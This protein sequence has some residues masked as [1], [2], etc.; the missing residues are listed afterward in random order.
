[1]ENV[2]ASSGLKVTWTRTEV[3][4]ANCEKSNYVTVYIGQRPMMKKYAREPFKIKVSLSQFQLG[5]K[6]MFVTHVESE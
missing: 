3:L 4:P 6:T 1:M 2:K 5:S